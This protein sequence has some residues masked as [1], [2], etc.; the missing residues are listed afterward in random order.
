MLQELSVVEQRYLAVREVLDGGKVTE[1]AT[2]YGGRPA[3]RAP[4]AGP[5]RHRGPGC[6][7]RPQLPSGPLPSPGQRD[8]AQADPLAATRPRGCHVRVLGP[9]HHLRPPC[10]INQED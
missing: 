8:R 5:L 10:S 3:Y 1:V 6:P 7:F 9:L 2:C 4:L